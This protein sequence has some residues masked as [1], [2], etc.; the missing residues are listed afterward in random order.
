MSSVPDAQFYFQTCQ[1]IAVGE[2]LLSSDTMLAVSSHGRDVIDY[3]SDRHFLTILGGLVGQS[4]KRRLTRVVVNNA[5]P[6]EQNYTHKWGRE[7]A[8]LEPV[9]LRYLA[10][11]GAFTLPSKPVRYGPDFAVNL[12][13]IFTNHKLIKSDLLLRLHFEHVYPYAPIL[14]RIELVRTYEAGGCSTFLLMAI[15]ASVVQYAPPQLLV[16]AGFSDRSTAQSKLFSNAVLL[17]DFGCEKS[18]LRRLQ[19]SLLL[20]ISNFSSTVDKDFRYWLYNAVR[21]ATKMGLHRR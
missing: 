16:D 3:H 5:P 8:G 12:Y 20:G 4:R 13:L 14:D 6:V 21:I 19:G 9:D 2:G 7:V 18:Q 10:A 15:F 1:E 17:Y 11:R